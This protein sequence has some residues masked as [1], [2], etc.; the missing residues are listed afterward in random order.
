MVT[1][2]G[3]SDATDGSFSFTIMINGDDDFLLGR[4]VDG[5]QYYTTVQVNIEEDDGTQENIVASSS[6]T[7]IDAC[8]R[9]FTT[10]CNSKK[11]KA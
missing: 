7:S 4:T 11:W 6:K 3:N 1:I 10:L 2:E 5:T 8:N 9:R